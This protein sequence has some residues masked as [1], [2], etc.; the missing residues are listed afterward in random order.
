MEVNRFFPDLDQGMEQIEVLLV[1]THTVLLLQ[2]KYL[3]FFKLRCFGFNSQLMG[4]LIEH[5]MWT[6]ILLGIPYARALF[7]HGGAIEQLTLVVVIC[8]Y[9]RLDICEARIFPSMSRELKHFGVWI[10]AS[11]SRAPLY[12]IHYLSS[13]LGRLIFEVAGTT[14][15]LHRWKVL[16]VEVHKAE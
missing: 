6:C 1:H 12:L 14:S 10:E 13:I 11:T 2:P 5:F 9:F 7:C 3:N 15:R 16:C 8:D 4:G